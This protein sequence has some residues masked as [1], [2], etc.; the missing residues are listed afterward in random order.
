MPVNSKSKSVRQQKRDRQKRKRS[1]QGN[2]D[3]QH[4]QQLKPKQKQ[5]KT[6]KQ[7]KQRKDPLVQMVQGFSES[8]DEEG[9]RKALSL[10]TSLENAA[11]IDFD[12]RPVA[13]NLGKKRKIT[14]SWLQKG[15][16]KTE[17]MNKK[18]RKKELADAR[19]WWKFDRTNPAFDA[20]YK[21]QRICPPEEWDAFM[22]KLQQPLPITFRVNSLHPGAEALTVRSHTQHLADGA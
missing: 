3:P 19:N 22:A 20:Y 15:S 10:P 14:D 11:T 7:K 16:Q 12:V 17:S 18:G 1:K 4:K 9:P 6:Q 2:H 8:D 13:P 21:K 5:K